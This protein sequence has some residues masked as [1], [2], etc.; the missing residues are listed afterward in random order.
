[1]F[2]LFYFIIIVLVAGTV[3]AG[4]YLKILTKNDDEHVSVASSVYLHPLPPD[5][6]ASTCINSESGK[7]MCLGTGY[8]FMC[9]CV[10]CE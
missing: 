1:M 8:V 6:K 10:K 2:I 7:L 3:V 5:A 9:V 4:D